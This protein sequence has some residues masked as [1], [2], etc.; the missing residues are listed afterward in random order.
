MDPSRIDRPSI[1]AV[2][3]PP[4]N[5]GTV[6]PTKVSSGVPE[7]G[8]HPTS[9]MPLPTTRTP[10]PI[11]QRPAGFVSKLAPSQSAPALSASESVRTAAPRS[12][13]EIETQIA[14]IKTNLSKLDQ[15]FQG[16]V[17][18]DMAKEGLAQVKDPHEK[19]NLLLNT[20]GE[21]KIASKKSLL[22]KILTGVLIVAAVIV[23]AAISATGIGAC[24][25]MMIGLAVG[26][27]IMFNKY[28]NSMLEDAKNTT[29]IDTVKDL[30]DL[31]KNDTFKEKLEVGQEAI[32]QNYVNEHDA[33]Q[34]ELA[35]ARQELDQAVDAQY[36]QRQGG[37]GP[38]GAEVVAQGGLALLFCCFN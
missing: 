17:A 37:I 20:L 3:I 18:R 28:K 34:K 22:L 19:L 6:M 23:V 32:L 24:V 29:S 38:D 35:N 9:A 12:I 2:S 11:P 8:V 33:F 13:K 25:G 21:D 16:S 36:G 14:D 4:G 30:K 1:Q 7:V 5:R 26:A 31:L 15:D 10:P 27:F